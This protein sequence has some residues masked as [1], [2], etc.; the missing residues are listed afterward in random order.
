[1]TYSD[2]IQVLNILNDQALNRTDTAQGTKR[3]DSARRNAIEY[4]ESGL[5][6]LLECLELF[7]KSGV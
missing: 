6:T 3:V 7:K 2:F 1:M 4:A 5:L